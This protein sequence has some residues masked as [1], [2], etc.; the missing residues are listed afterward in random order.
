[1]LARQAASWS[2]FTIVFYV[3][4]FFEIGAHELFPPAD[5]NLDP[6]YIYKRET[7][8]YTPPTPCFLNQQA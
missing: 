5:S 8:G 4:D 1:M 2:H 6:S 7:P 3:L